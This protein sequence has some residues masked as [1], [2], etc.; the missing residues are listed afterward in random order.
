MKGMKKFLWS[1]GK[2]QYNQEKPSV[3]VP[4]LFHFTVTKLQFN[5]F[6][7]ITF[8]QFEECVTNIL[9]SDKIV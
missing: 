4:K 1:N 6:I 5:F 8:Y 2:Y 7:A 9:R 3:Y